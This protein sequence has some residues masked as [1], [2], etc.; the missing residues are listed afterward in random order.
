M[1]FTYDYLLSNI[2]Y[3]SIIVIIS[4]SVFCLLVYSS[5]IGWADP[6]LYCAVIFGFGV[7][8]LEYVQMVFGESCWT[9]I[10]QL[11][12]FVYFFS[13]FITNLILEGLFGGINNQIDNVRIKLNGAKPSIIYKLYIIFLVG[14]LIAII[15]NSIFSLEMIATGYVGDERLILRQDNR[16]LDLIK[17]DFLNIS[18]FLAGILIGCNYNIKKKII[19]IFISLMAISTIYCGSKAFLISIILTYYFGIIFVR[20]YYKIRLNHIVLLMAGLFSIGVAR[21]IWGYENINIITTLITRL[22][23]SGDAYIYSPGLIDQA[24]LYGTYDAFDYLLH[25]IYRLFKSSGY[26][27]PL[28]VEL[29]GLVTGNFEGNGPNA[30]YPLLVGVLS[31][32]SLL[33]IYLAMFILGN[34]TVL[35]RYIGVAAF[36]SAWKKYPVVAV[37]F[38]YSSFTLP[39]VIMVD[40]GAFQQLVIGNIFVVIFLQLV[41][42]IVGLKFRTPAWGEN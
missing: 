37:G 15:A 16:A 20:K 18:I 23:L 32:G 42:I 12:Y 5:I 10:Y 3:L 9:R 2:P 8:N 39:I 13:I 33:I 29:F 1:P 31:N 25:P 38:L 24:S 30:V 22:F 21:I 27:N 17:R 6:L 36:N 40:I 34:I 4:V 35:C 41:M 14:A 26:D 19:F 28:G 7:A 11:S